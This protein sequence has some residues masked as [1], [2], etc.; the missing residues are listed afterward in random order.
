MIEFKVE[1]FDDFVE[2]LKEIL[3]DHA[4][5]VENFSEEV[6]IEPIYEFYKE[7]SEQGNAVFYTIRNDQEL[8]GYAVFLIHG[9]PHRGMANCATNDLLYIKP[10]YRHTG[11]S[12]MFL[13]S[14][15][16]D[17]QKIEVEMV[18]YSMKTKQTFE[19]LMSLMGYEHTEC[20]FQKVIKNG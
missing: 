20:V 8:V 17:L 7:A 3:F 16:E 19:T 14:C 4:E 10:E 18:S 5:E 9:N 11:L 15:E 13:K 12:H 6:P 2:D 1:P